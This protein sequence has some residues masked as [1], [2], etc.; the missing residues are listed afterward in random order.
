MNTRIALRLIIVIGA[1]GIAGAALGQGSVREYLSDTALRVQATDNPVEKRELLSERLATL[2][3][4]IDVATHA[5]LT[6]AKDD[7][8][9]TRIKTTLQER[10][11]ELAGT[12]GFER[13]PDAQINAF[14]T[15]I[16]QDLEQ[17]DSTVTISTVTLLLILIIVLLVA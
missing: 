2:T 15:Y 8:S 1:L 11:D 13:V 10:S 7:L 3:R 16:V 4:A 6:S 17:A 5:P 12:N 14:S 9:L